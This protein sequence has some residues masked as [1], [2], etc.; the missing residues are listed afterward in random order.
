MSDRSQ[1]VLDIEGVQI[2][3]A[4][5]GQNVGARRSI[6]KTLLPGDADD[7]VR[8]LFAH[9][10]V[11]AASGTFSLDLRTTADRFGANLAADDV[12]VLFVENVEDPTGGGALEVR[13]GAANGF[14]NLLGTGSALKLPLGAFAIVGCFKADRIDVTLTNKTLD[15]V[16][17]GAALPV[18]LR[19]QAWVRR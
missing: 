18:L 19:I 9:E 10:A 2:A 13:P 14:T 3:P 7:E 1:F 11:L 12:V 4:P 8:A 15:F 5:Y 16:E 6:R 17:T